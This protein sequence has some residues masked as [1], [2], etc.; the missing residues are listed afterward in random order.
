MLQY[1]ISKLRQALKEKKLDGLLISNFHN[2]LYLSGFKTLTENERE[3]WVLIT[4]EN[5]YL[6]TDSRYLNFKF[7]ISN[8]KF[9]FGLYILLM[10]PL[11]P[12]RQS[13]LRQF[14]EK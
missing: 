2:I 12:R 3:A 8:S 5:C 6:F 9:P 11:N 1:R 10:N 13:N 7:Q 14:I 4:A